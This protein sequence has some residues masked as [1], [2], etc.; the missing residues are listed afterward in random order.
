[1]MNIDK[2]L[3]GKKFPVMRMDIF[4]LNMSQKERKSERKKEFQKKKMKINKY[5]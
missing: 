5:K 3:P 2:G 4:H 1:M